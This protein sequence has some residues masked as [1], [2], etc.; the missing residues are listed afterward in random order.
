M[1]I[2]DFLPDSVLVFWTRLCAWFSSQ[3]YAVML[4][5]AQQHLL[6]RLHA[7]LDLQ[8]LV[9]ACAGYHHTAGPGDQPTHPVAYLV[10]AVLVK[11]LYSWSLR[12]CADQI[13]H[14][15]VIK[16][17]VGYPVFA[18]GPDYTTLARFEAWVSEHHGRTFF[19]VTLQQIDADF[20]G[21]RRQ[22]QVGDTFAMQANAAKE[23]LVRLIRHT[24]QCLLRVLQTADP[25]AYAAV[26]GQLAAVALFGA[27]DERAEFY[28][29]PAARRVRLQTTVVAAL[30]CAEL[31]Q[32][33]LPPT[34]PAAARQPVTDRLADL[35]KLVADEV[36]IPRDAH[37]AITRIE[38]L[39]PK[40]Q[41]SYRLGSAT[42]PA[43][44]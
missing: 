11:T 39:P 15:L 21:E 42:D 28:L 5:H 8:A 4:A 24:W 10:R 12:E 13:N 43:A 9:T 7:R 2:P 29:D 3:V 1:P 25:V 37:G 36:A 14:H 33:H 32:A 41:G 26:T 31:V 38:A 44:T 20:P 34:L 30:H 16:W 18:S 6:V 23:G 17:F 22:P 19:D 27:P 40:Q 35:T